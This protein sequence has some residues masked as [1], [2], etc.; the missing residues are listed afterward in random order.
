[1]ISK[2]TLTVDNGVIKSA[3]VYAKKRNMSIS[4]MVEGYLK[5]VTK[6]QS[7]EFELPE[8][9]MKIKG[10]IKQLPNKYDWKKDVAEAKKEKY[11]RIG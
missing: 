10:M 3:K 4:K 2:L 8:E 9:L 1:M 5:A 6:Q 7:K 11:K